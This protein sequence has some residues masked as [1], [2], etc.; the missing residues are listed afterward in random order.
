MVGRKHYLHR[1]AGEQDP[2]MPV[3]PKLVQTATQSL[4]CE[5]LSCMNRAAVFRRF[6]GSEVEIGPQ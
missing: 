2:R 4:V 6:T 1:T 5:V 3:G